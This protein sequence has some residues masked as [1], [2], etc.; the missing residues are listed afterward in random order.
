MDIAKQLASLCVNNSYATRVCYRLEYNTYISSD[1]NQT[2]NFAT[3]A[4]PLDLSRVVFITTRSTASASEVV[5]NSLKPYIDVYIVGDTTHG[6]PCGMNLWGYPFDA[7]SESEFY[8]LFAPVT[9]E[10]TNAYWQGRFYDGM[11]PNELAT[12]DIMHDFGDPNE[13][14]LKTAIALL[15]GKKSVSKVP[16]HRTTVFSEGTPLPTELIFGKPKGFQK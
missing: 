13:H 5:I 7:A 1:W 14:S 10:Y 8:Y 4:S 3:T 16:Y 9:F 12:D 6:K 2:F 11:V 15:E